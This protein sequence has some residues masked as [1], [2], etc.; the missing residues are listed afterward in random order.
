MH[1]GRWTWYTAAALLAVMAV[2]FTVA[3]IGLPALAEKRTEIENFIS[4]QSSYPVRI[5]DLETY[6]RGL[7]PGLRIKKLEIFSSSDLTRAVQLAE[8]RVSLALLPLLWGE[9][10]I[11]SLVVVNPSLALERLAD[12]RLRVTGF[13]PLAMRER[14]ENGKLLPWLLD[15]KQLI[16]EDGELQWFDHQAGRQGFYLSKINV[17]LHN[18]GNHHELGITADFPQELCTDCSLV[19]ELNGNPATSKVWDGKIFLKAIGIDLARLPAIVRD[20]LPKHVAGKFDLQLWTTWRDGKLLAAN[21]DASVSRLALPIKSLDAPLAVREARARLQWK[22]RGG[23]WELNLEDLWLGL[24]GPAWSAGNVQLKQDP[25][26]RT[27]EVSRLDIQDVATFLTGL[28]LKNKYVQ[29]LKVVN[30]RGKLHGLKLRI[31]G[32]GTKPDDFSLQARVDG[33]VSEP[34][35]K[36]PG[37]TGIT[38]QLSARGQAGTFLL[39]SKNLTLSAPHVFRVPLDFGKVTAHVGWALSSK[40]VHV[41]GE[42]V[43]VNAEDGQGE[44]QVELRVPLDR[45]KKPYINL[46]ATFKDGNGAHASRYYPINLLTDKTVA[47]LDDSLVSGFVTS[48]QVIYDGNVADF[49]FRDGNGEFE[50]VAHVRDG[51]FSYLP[52]WVPVTGAEADVRF[53]NNKMLI[54]GHRG[55][56]GDLDVEQVIVSAD[57]LRKH[58][59]SIVKVT[60]TGNGP[61]PEALSILRNNPIARNKKSWASYFGLGFDV[62]GHGV[63]DLRLTIPIRHASAFSLD[64]EYLVERGTLSFRVPRLRAENVHGTVRFNKDGPTTG[65]L[66]GRF[67]GGNA[68]VDLEGQ[69]LEGIQDTHLSGRGTFTATGLA[70]ALQWPIDDYLKGSSA[71]AGTMLLRPGFDRLDVQ[72]NLRGIESTLPAPLYKPKDESVPLTLVSKRSAPDKRRLS[73]DAG[74]RIAARLNFTRQEE[75]WT[76]VRGVVGVGVGKLKWPLARGLQIKAR[77]RHADADAWLQV[78]RVGRGTGMPAFIKRFS[79]QFDSVFLLNR[80]CGAL[81][82]DLARK[83]YVWS[84]AMGGDSLEGQI[85]ITER[86][87]GPP[88]IELDMA[89][90]VIREK[91]PEAGTTLKN[92]RDLPGVILKA[93]SLAYKDRKL[94]ALDFEAIPR[95]LG[96]QIVRL[97]LTRPETRVSLKGD[98]LAIGEEQVTELALQIN[99]TNFGETLQA[100]GVP[101]RLEGS[102]LEAKSSLSWRGS[103]LDPVVATLD[104]NVELLAKNGRLPQIER[105]AGRLLGVLDFTSFGN[106]S[107]QFEKGLPFNTAKGSF[108]IENGDAYTHNSYLKGSAVHISFNGRVGIAARDYDMAMRVVPKFGTNIVL[109]GVLPQVGMA[110]LALEKLFEKPVS[111]STRMTYVVTGSWDNPTINRLGEKSPAPKLE[112]LQDGGN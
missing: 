61:V 22:K 101:D 100:W 48:G 36:I 94:G 64:G 24:S 26:G 35:R 98:W 58:G 37:V 50:V 75:D 38:G 47:W 18:K 66:R 11:N 7:R 105:G 67:L 49:P 62:D 93:K 46:R 40:E 80:Q 4:A 6:W 85:R 69:G 59:E 55:K 109:W 42:N 72:A 12:G 1:V 52:G 79:A 84:G 88:D 106:L 33:F 110:L 27:I 25:R 74:E 21:G 32:D 86:L 95:D 31:D 30:P 112:E 43:R 102:E 41:I 53:R 29:T 56:V 76:F 89:R 82:L 60:A 90:L 13:E 107:Q 91:K 71:W 8:V 111:K 23:F 83:G 97:E 87:G 5:G 2:V 92:P 68:V 70:R 63:L 103:P 96:W 3:R 108:A 73:I 20:A 15:Q 17:N 65:T 77:G 44:G 10:Q 57:D 34:F 104:G 45:S 78:L 81:R 51:V 19:L 28:G 16:I 9:L 39:D 14:S 99:S 54:T